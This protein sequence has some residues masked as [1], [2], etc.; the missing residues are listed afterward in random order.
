M[1]ERLLITNARLVDPGDA[2]ATSAARSPIADGRDR[3]RR[4]RRA[5]RL[6]A[7]RT[8]DAGGAVVAPGLVDLCARLGEPGHEHEGLLESE[9]AAAVAGGV[10]SLVCPPDTD[11]VL[12]EPGLV[13]MLKFRAREPRPGARLSARRADARPRRRGADRDGRAHR[14]RLR[15]LR[16]GRRGD[17]RHAGPAPRAAVRG[18]LRLHGRGCGRT[19]PG[20]ATA[21]P[22]RGR[23]RPAWASRACRC[24][25]RRSPWRRSSSSCA[26]P[27][28]ASTSAA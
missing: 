14:G 5:G 22:P 21:S 18:D 9:L 12:D 11:P 25:P 26:T 24:S 20:S 7:E 3:R 17:P 4:R 15:R 23:W 10:T 28:R 13:E 8:I 1:T 2:A 16:A 19:T 6:H 27:A